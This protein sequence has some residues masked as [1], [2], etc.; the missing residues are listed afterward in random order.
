LAELAAQF[1]E[2]NAFGSL[3]GGA[4]DAFGILHCSTCDDGGPTCLDVTEAAECAV[5]DVRAGVAHPLP[6]CDGTAVVLAR[7]GGPRE[8]RRHAR[9]PARRGRARRRPVADHNR[10]EVR[11]R[12]GWGASKSRSVA[13]AALVTLAACSG[14]APEGASACE[15]TRLAY[16]VDPARYDILFVI[17]EGTSM[18]DE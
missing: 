10:R 14:Q 7:R 13:V 4:A 16:P 5:S 18:V 9:P 2:R 1:P 15:V 8:L 6:R 17:S 11:M 3:C 12:L